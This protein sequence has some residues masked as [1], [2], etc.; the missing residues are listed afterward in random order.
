VRDAYVS[1]AE[2]L[3]ELA[4]A[5][6][7]LEGGEFTD[8]DKAGAL[9]DNLQRVVD[10]MP[11][12][13]E[14]RRMQEFIDLLRGIEDAGEGVEDID[15]EE[16]LPTGG[17]TIE[18]PEIEFDKGDAEAQAEDMG[19]SI[20]SFLGDSMGPAMQG[21][22]LGTFI[23]PGWGTLV[24]GALGMLYGTVTQAWD[25]LAEA[26]PDG[27]SMWDWIGDISFQQEG[28]AWDQFV[29]GIKSIGTTIWDEI[30][31]L[32]ES[33]VRG[34][35]GALSFFAYLITDWPGEMWEKLKEKIREVFRMRSPSKAM[36]ELGVDAVAGFLEGMVNKFWDVLGWAG[37]TAEAV[38]TAIGEIFFRVSGTA[39]T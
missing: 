6:A 30:W 7:L 16:A 39:R 27:M 13:P 31:G 12:G 18:F 37:G 28:S 38:K 19:E 10:A 1:Q 5:T 9:A 36:A 17:Q 8:A 34:F 21:A 32:G 23:A 22:L 20:G 25:K 14:K 15:W 2:A 29:T 11:E 24:G 35:A 3:A 33:V 26:K 4:E